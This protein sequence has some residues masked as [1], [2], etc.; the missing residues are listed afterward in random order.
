VGLNTVVDEHFGINIVEFMAAGV[1][2]IVHAS[3][4]PK[5]DI[6]VRYQDGET[7]KKFFLSLLCAE[8][9]DLINNVYIL[10]YHA[11]DPSSY[12]EAINQVLALSPKEALA[13]RER[14][15][16]SAVKRFSEE[17][18]LKAW[19]EALGEGGYRG[20]FRH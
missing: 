17:M 8:P 5:K 7:G 12:A 11:T 6:V 16:E 4:A 18:F 1:I 13:M 19:D 15:R 10:G 20:W 2:P 14:A 9:K 3:G